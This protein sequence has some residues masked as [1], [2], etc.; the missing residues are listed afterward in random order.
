M[1]TADFDYDLPKELIA[2]HPA[3]ERSSSRLFVLDRSG[4]QREHKRFDDIA[5]YLRPGDLLV[6]NESRVVPARL[7]GRKATGGGVEVLLVGPEGPGRWSCLVKGLR[8]TTAAAEVA[9]GAT[10]ATLHPAGEFWTVTFPGDTDVEALME[11]QGAMPLPPYI[12]RV[13]G[14]SDRDMERYQTVYARVAGSIAAPTAGFH[15]T[16]DLLERLV[17]KGVEIVRITLHIGVGTFFLMKSEEV[18]NHRMH[19]EHFCLAVEAKEAIFRARRDGR[20][21]I[22]C[23]TSAVRT[24]ET[25]AAG[26]GTSLLE[27]STDLFVSP[28][29]RFALVD[30]LIT[31]FHLPRS[32]PLMLAAAFAGKDELLSCY[33]E[34]IAMGYRFY[35]YGDGMLI[36]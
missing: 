22:A 5:S 1:K 29:H 8:R 11:A 36:L 28:G 30:C 27:G 16:D 12:K 20:R 17:R 34:A 4:G 26:N 3:G 7:F 31:N 14:R 25:L 9:F 6:L 13:R 21:I 32:T 24:L 19:A 35:S 15:F 18:G 33:R 10:T 23:G 2:Q